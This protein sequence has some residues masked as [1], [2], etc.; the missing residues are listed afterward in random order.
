MFIL[1]KVEFL[2]K[3]II[4]LCLSSEF[5]LLF[6]LEFVDLSFISTNVASFL[7]RRKKKVS[8]KREGDINAFF[9]IT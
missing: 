7:K 5:I 2:K 8:R 6:G 3:A 4:Y 1:L 9:K